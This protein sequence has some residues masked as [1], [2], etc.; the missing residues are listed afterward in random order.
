VVATT[1]KSVSLLSP[2]TALVRFDTERR[3]AGGAP[4]PVQSWSAVVAFRYSGAPMRMEDR[5]LNPLGFE[6]TRYRRDAEAPSAAA[7]APAPGATP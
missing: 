1:V 3:E 4:E 5:F 6:V 2:T 7:P